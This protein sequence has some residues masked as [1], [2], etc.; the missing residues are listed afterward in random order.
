MNSCVMCQADSIKQARQK[1]LTKTCYSCVDVKYVQCSRCLNK[2]CS[3]CIVGMHEYI[4][5]SIY[6]NVYEN[7]CSFVALN[8]MKTI[9]DDWEVDE[10]GTVSV[11]QGP[12]CSFK[13]AIPKT[14]KPTITRPPRPP[15]INST[16]SKRKV[17]QEED[18]VFQNKTDAQESWRRRKN[19]IVVKESTLEFLESYHDNEPSNINPSNILQRPHTILFNIN[20]HRRKNRKSK[21]KAKLHHNVFEGALIL[22]MYDI[23]FQADASENHWGCDHMALAESSDG[24]PGAIHGCPSLESSDRAFCFVMEHNSNPLRINGTTQVSVD[25]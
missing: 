25:I 24:T 22:P 17:D 8:S 18:Y 7:D 16:V 11:P 12:C 20:K 13:G 23:A 3:S 2:M 10:I 21:G 15:T 4:R 19:R 9:L 6:K 14:S 5:S 1:I